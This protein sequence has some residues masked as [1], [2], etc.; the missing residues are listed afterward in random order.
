MKGLYTKKLQEHKL[1]KELQ[2][3]LKDYYNLSLHKE[4][5]QKTYLKKFNFKNCRSGEVIK[6]DYDFEQKYKEYSKTT[7][8]RVSTI[9][10]MAHRKEFVSVFITFTLPSEYHPFKSIK[11]GNERLYT[12]I[13]PD[14]SFNSIDEAVSQ[15]YKHL[16]KIYQTFY[17]RVKNYTKNDLYYVKAIEQHNSTIPHLHLLIF[18]PL[19]K[20]EFIKTTFKRVVNHFNLTV[21]DYQSTN[22]NE[23][24][25]YA[26]NYLLKYITKDLNSGADYFQARVLDGWKRKHKIR[27]LSNSNLPLTL[28][29]YKQIYHSISNIEKKRLNLKKMIIY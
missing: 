29:I 17:K 22:F 4:H 27:V 23:S 15:G 8:Q 28:K 16:N 21:V 9:S 25:S 13:N 5:K 18:F 14:F 10:A 3:N 6:L 26:S 19:E 2:Q 1:Y 11:K 24:I 20:A 7:Q 12:S